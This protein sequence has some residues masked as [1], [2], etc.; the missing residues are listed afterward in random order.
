VE[1]CSSEDRLK[2]LL[3]LDDGIADV[4]EDLLDTGTVG[5]AERHALPCCLCRMTCLS[6][7]NQAEWDQETLQS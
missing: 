4:C 5:D 1:Y 7:A 3:Q 6:V 2:A